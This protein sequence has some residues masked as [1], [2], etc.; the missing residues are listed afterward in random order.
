M[1]RLRIILGVLAV[2]LSLNAYALSP[3][4]IGTSMAAKSQLSATVRLSFQNGV[5]TGVKVAPKTYLTAAHCLSPHIVGTNHKVILGVNTKRYL[6]RALENSL[7]GQMIKG[8]SKSSYASLTSTYTVKDYSVGI[9]QVYRHPSY[10]DETQTGAD[11]GL[12]VIDK[13]FSSIPKAKIAVNK[14]VGDILDTDFYLNGYGYTCESQSCYQQFAEWE[15]LLTKQRRGETLTLNEQ[16][17]IRKLSLHF[18]QATELKYFYSRFH[19]LA[20]DQK[21]IL[22]SQSS[23]LAY[24]DSGGPV[25]IKDANGELVIVAINSSVLND[26]NQGLLYNQVTPL[27]RDSP[28]GVSAFLLKYLK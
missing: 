27:L 7:L 23:S 22:L 28:F 13:E 5:C 21:I 8:L 1:G 11:I 18:K 4:V 10:H 15:T 6:S 17:K 3:L 2:C 12:L 24:G 25:Y 20:R 26:L 19:S 16:D 9:A 14:Q